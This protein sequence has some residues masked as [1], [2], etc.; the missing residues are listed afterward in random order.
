MKLLSIVLYTY[1]LC[2]CVFLAITNHMTLHHHH[3]HNVA[4]LIVLAGIYEILHLVLV[5]GMN[6]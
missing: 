6:L 1:A 5:L 2:V 4:T 3:T